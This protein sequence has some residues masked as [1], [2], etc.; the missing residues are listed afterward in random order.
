[1]RENLEGDKGIKRTEDWKNM[2]GGT[3]GEEL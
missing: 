1:M 3:K 2:G